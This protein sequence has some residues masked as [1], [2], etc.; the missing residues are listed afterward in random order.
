VSLTGQVCALA[1]GV[2]VRQHPG[3]CGQRSKKWQRSSAE[4]EGSNVLYFQMHRAVKVQINMS[5]SGL[6]IS[7]GSGPRWRFNTPKINYCAR[8]PKR[9]QE[10]GAMNVRIDVSSPHTCQFVFYLEMKREFAQSDTYLL[11]F[12]EQNSQNGWHNANAEKKII[13]FSQN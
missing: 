13:H 4:D 3:I 7:A 11:P 10:I 6:N 5:E 8:R 1:A 9:C 2:N 12:F